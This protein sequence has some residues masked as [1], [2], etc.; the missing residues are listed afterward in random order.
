MR[1]PR[2]RTAGTGR[3]LRS[4]RTSTGA[5]LGYT[6][7]HLV[8]L[9]HPVPQVNVTRGCSSAPVTTAQDGNSPE[10]EPQGTYVP[11][12]PSLRG[13]VLT[14]AAPSARS[15]PPGSLLLTLQS[16]HHFL[17]GASQPPGAGRGPIAA[18]L[19]FLTLSGPPADLTP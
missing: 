12:A 17:R 5:T 4:H 8:L 7:P 16:K 1:T 14:S 15:A 10:S 2:I 11:L 6:H 9:P 19:L 3:S 13:R 18:V